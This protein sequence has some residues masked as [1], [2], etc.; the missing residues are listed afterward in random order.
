M[1]NKK[2]L[3]IKSNKNHNFEIVISGK[4][5]LAVQ[6]T[7][8]TENNEKN[9]RKRYKNTIY[10][11]ENLKSFEHL[12]NNEAFQELS[13]LSEIINKLE[14]KD[15]QLNEEL[16]N[17]FLIIRLPYA[18]DSFIYINIEQLNVEYYLT[19]G[20]K[21]IRIKEKPFYSSLNDQNFDIKKIKE[22]LDKEKIINQFSIDNYRYYDED[23]KGFITLNKLRNYKTPKNTLILEL[24][25]SGNFDS[26]KSKLE[27]INCNLYNKI[28][29]IKHRKN[30]NKQM[31]KE[32]DLIFLY[33]SPLLNSSGQESESIKPINYR[34]EIKEIVNSFNKTGYSYNI[35]F[36]CANERLFTDVL[37]NSKTKILHISSHG[38]H[39]LKDDEFSL[40]LED[41]IKYQKINSE[42][43][44][45]ILK[46]NSSKIK[47]IDLVIVSACY[48]QKL[49]KLF[50]KYKAK[51]VIYIT[52]ETPISSIAAIK[53]TKLFYQ[54]LV[55]NHKSIKDAFDKA[56]KDLKSDREIICNKPNRCCCSHLH[57][58]SCS[59]NVKQI[60][61]KI[62]EEFHNKKCSCHFIELHMH[63]P[64]CHLYEAIKKIIEDEK[65]KDKKI[66]SISEE[67][68][69]KNGENYLKICCC[70]YKIKHGEAMKFVLKSKQNSEN[71]ILF[72]S[73]S[74]QKGK[75]ET[76]K[77]YVFD[78]EE[79]KGF[80][81]FGRF[82]I[83]QTI[84]H[85]VTNK[86][87][88]K[89]HFIIIY[90]DREIG[91]QD[92]A[93]SVC[94]HL[95]ERK[96]IKDYDGC[97]I[98]SNEYD[99]N[100]IKNKIINYNKNQK[101]KIIVILKIDYSLDENKSFF[102]ANK[103]LQNENIIENNNLY[104][105]ILISTQK[106]DIGKEIKGSPCIIDLKL[107][108]DSAIKLVQKL[109]DYLGFREKFL[110]ELTKKE[111]LLQK[112]IYQPKIIKTI[113][114]LANEI[115]DITKLEKIV[116]NDDFNDRSRTGYFELLMEKSNIF[117][118]YYLLSIMP[119]GLPESL[120]KL[121]Y[122]DYDKIMKDED[123]RQLLFY[124]DPND[125]WK[126]I[127]DFIK[128]NSVFEKKGK[129]ELKSECISNCL[130]VY[131]KLL[132]FY[133][134]NNRENICFPDT[135]IH[136]I[137]NSYNGTGIWKT[138]D[139]PMYEYCFLNETNNEEY[140]KYNN[141][142]KDDFILERH[143][144]NIASLILN[145]LEKLGELIKNEVNKEYLEQILIML[146]SCYFLKRECITIIKKYINVCEHEELKL[147]LKN[148][149]KRLLLFLY[150]IDNNQEI[151]LE[152]FKESQ[153]DQNGLEIEAYFL[154]ALITKEKE[155]FEE[156]IK[157]NYNYNGESSTDKGLSLNTI[158]Y[159]YYELAVLYNS[160][161]DYTNALKYLNEA[162]TL[163]KKSNNFFLLDRINID[164]FLIKKKQLN[165]LNKEDS[166]IEDREKNETNETNKYLELLLNEVFDS[167]QNRY[168]QK[169][170]SV[171]INEVYNLMLEFNKE[172][173]NDIVILNSNPLKN[174]T[175]LLTRGIY[176]RL[177]N[178]Y[179]ILEKLQEKIKKNLKIE[180]KILN[181]NNLLEALNQNG[182]ILIIQADD[183]TK[184]GEI[185]YESSFESKELL[186]EIL[187]KKYLP[188]KI[189]YSVV[190]LCFIKSGKLKELFEDKVQYL[191]TFDDIDCY[192]L[193][194][195][196]LYK[197]N[198]LSIDFLINFIEK[199]T[200]T[201]NVKI[202]T[203]F[204]ESKKLFVDGLKDYNNFFNNHNYIT[205]TNKNNIKSSIKYKS[206]K[207]QGSIYL[208]Q[209]LIEMPTNYLLNKDFLEEIMTIIKEILSGEK[210][211]NVYINNDNRIKEKNYKALNKKTMISI[212]IM[213]Y[214]YRHQLFDKLYYIDNPQKYGKSLNEIINNVLEKVEKREE[215]TPSETT[216]IIGKPLTIFILINNYEK[217][218]EKTKKK[219]LKYEEPLKL[220]DNVNYL[221]VTKNKI[222]VD[223]NIND[224]T[225][226]DNI[227][228][229]IIMKGID[230]NIKTIQL[231]DYIKFGKS[232][233]SK[234]NKKNTN[235]NKI[236][237]NEEN[238]KNENN[239]GMDLFKDCSVFNCSFESDKTEL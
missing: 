144:K 45:N 15:I 120:I 178:Q 131:S 210:F 160:E 95:Y 143:E 62:H 112:F 152:E 90:G 70:D 125:N 165:L 14:E 226:N 4:T 150:S 124:S 195:D 129:S 209:K 219:E 24:H 148:S 221:V 26:F 123:V 200:E 102:L 53:F 218:K 167:K 231:E 85:I 67:E 203:I 16:Y 173:E 188:V 132:F 121:I 122:P 177:N 166:V 98:I 97:F 181:E 80:S 13:D 54:E 82:E 17:L 168:N 107:N 206:R 48:S 110:Y 180:S 76:N 50:I 31:T 11:L 194:Y 20:P 116:L 3:T 186:K 2:R 142:I 21:H 23:L 19:K 185:T 198:E 161:K 230:F 34:K 175:S 79:N 92:F 213:K 174:N 77:N 229:E 18:D 147:K 172:S 83:V 7:Q 84:I 220:I 176:S 184:N 162:K 57:K 114:D 157:N 93:E 10:P 164:T 233:K 228:N 207:N 66:F 73:E 104:F 199:T 212:E 94:V 208:N 140:N 5:F 75:L 237:I 101:E 119:S 12:K 86:N 192:K 61:D 88:N 155:I 100:Y 46:I 204:E 117:K 235:E 130:R 211:I 145:N 40:I 55:V 6:I 170:Q 30:V 118:I 28:K 105:I 22:M 36:E 239:K 137:F 41:K 65:D 149:K 108:G 222:I 223:N 171:M 42:R 9:P 32:Y 227:K 187:E 74:Q 64:N 35:L 133:I 37:M 153:N 189:K 238:E 63:K 156:L 115:N 169:L 190:I 151:N 39:N 224:N 47:N 68:E 38:E 146:P 103:I 196:I 182:K 49:G 191:I 135:N 1:N 96:I 52:K 69:N 43:L 225:N 87:I 205:L 91:K 25:I 111:S 202:E 159:A 193:N 236:I 44:E 51:N 113:L 71:I 197:Y 60:K 33:A 138:F 99:L 109:G 179:Y 81:T 128:D 27:T 78:F 106:H 89:S 8:K 217:A 136:Y 56:Q 215:Y 29:N 163:S 141:I 58:K 154:K 158:I 232:K 234:S 126:H 183:Y 139:L 127:K 59:L 72:K 134:E 216:D 214:L 201:K